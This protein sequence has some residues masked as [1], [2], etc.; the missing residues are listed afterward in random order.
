MTSK[1]LWFILDHPLKQWP[2]GK[3]EGKTEKQKSEYLNNKKSFLDEIKSIFHNC[4]SAI[5]CLKIINSEHKL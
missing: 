5:I 2:A 4:L 3:K 1:T